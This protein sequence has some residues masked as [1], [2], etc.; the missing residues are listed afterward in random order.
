MRSAPSTREAAAVWDIAIPSPPSRLPGVSMAGFRDRD[1]MA[2]AGITPT[3]V[4][5]AP[6][7]AVDD[8]A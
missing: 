4:A 2:F 3:A 6:W 5:I 1:V 8:V 7:L